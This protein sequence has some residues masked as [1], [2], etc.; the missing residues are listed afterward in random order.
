MAG[1]S[2]PYPSR[3]TSL[4]DRVHTAPAQGGRQEGFRLHLWR[5]CRRELRGVFLE[6]VRV[7]RRICT[8]REALLRFFTVL[9]EL[10]E[11]VDPDHYSKPL[12]FKRTPTTFRPDSPEVVGVIEPIMAV[13]QRAR[14]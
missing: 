14:A 1:F 9:A 11:R 12:A 13:A 10:D 6:Y 8:T 7:G 3:A 4:A 5:W 2:R